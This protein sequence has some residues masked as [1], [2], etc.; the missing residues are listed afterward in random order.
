[1]DELEKLIE[2]I[3]EYFGC[4]AAYYSIDAADFAMYLMDKNVGIKEVD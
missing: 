2:I 3:N 1:M 4:D